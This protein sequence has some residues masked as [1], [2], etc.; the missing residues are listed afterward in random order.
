MI[1]AV[2]LL[3]TFMLADSGPHNLSFLGVIRVIYNKHILLLYAKKSAIS[4]KGLQTFVLS[5]L[6]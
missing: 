3:P 5:M 2:T 4:G 6:H 1:G